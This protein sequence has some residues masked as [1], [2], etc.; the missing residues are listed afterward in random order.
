MARNLQDKSLIITGASSGIGAAVAREAAAHGMHVVLNARREERLVALAK[1]IEKIGRRAVIVAGDI[2]EP[3]MPQK[4][5]DRTVE[6]FGQ[7]NVMFAN[8]GY[9]FMKPVVQMDDAEL[10]K[11]FEV[12]Y[13]A[14]VRC[15]QAAAAHMAPRKA[16]HIIITSSI[17]GRVG[18]PY[19]AAYSATKS[20]QDTFAMGMR[21]ELELEGIDLSVLYPIG[22]KTE[23]FD[24]SAEIGGQDAI[25]EN[26]P[27]AFMQSA[28]HVA[29]RVVKCMQKP[30][31]EIW[32]ARW[33]R[34]GAGLALLS[35][36]LTR[37]A[38]R[39]HAAKDRKKYGL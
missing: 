36:G 27:D 6:Q 21:P 17:V 11:I 9:G 33:S 18:L 7:V 24:V 30:K 1:E 19:Y 35:P 37:W 32:P 5:I 12:N 4:L 28:E 34:I 20:A 29:R 16:G 2:A 23:F 15:M 22:T 3:D 10:R 31:L 13:F 38:L 8:A 25:S 14:C 39:K 26:T